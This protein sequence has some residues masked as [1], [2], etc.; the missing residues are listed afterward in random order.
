M[1]QLRTAKNSYD[2]FHFTPELALVGLV[3]SME[4]VGLHYFEAALDTPK[5]Y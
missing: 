5:V 3:S 1:I 4:E 2:A